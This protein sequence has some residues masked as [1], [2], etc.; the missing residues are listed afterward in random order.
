[1]WSSN[2]RRWL[3]RGSEEHPGEDLPRDPEQP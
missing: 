1:V 3:R 2:L